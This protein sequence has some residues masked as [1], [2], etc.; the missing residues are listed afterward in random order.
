M[1]FLHDGAQCIRSAMSA[2]ELQ[3]IRNAVAYQPLQQAGVRVHGIG[4]TPTFS[5]LLGNGGCGR[6]L[7]SRRHMSG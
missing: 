6:M 1:T 3:G 2:T 4:R 7:H 5:D